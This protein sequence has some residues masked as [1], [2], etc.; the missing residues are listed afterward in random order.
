MEISVIF[1]GEQSFSTMKTPLKI[2]LLAAV[3]ALAAS[4]C[5]CRS[6][7]KKT[8]RPLE[9]TRWQ[10]VQL[11]GQDVACD[12]GT[13]T[14]VFAPKESS[15]SGIGA[16]NRIKGPYGATDKRTLRI[17]PL[18]TTRRGCPDTERETKFVRLLEATTHYDMDGPLLLLLADGEIRVVLQALP[19]K[20]E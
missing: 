6:Y 19:E 9:G 15:L 4:C 18:V 20:S 1:V 13:F 14:V 10:L 17:G 7:Q 12:P 8:R 5:A 2:L 16:C 11:D 3:A